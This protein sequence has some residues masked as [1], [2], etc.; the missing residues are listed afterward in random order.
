MKHEIEVRKSYINQRKYFQTIINF[1][2]L[3]I[4]YHFPYY[5]FVNAGITFFY[6]TVY[7][8]FQLKTRSNLNL[9][10]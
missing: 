1:Y 8:I 5:T 3:L 2:L 6:T 9:F 10:A 4:P 7:I